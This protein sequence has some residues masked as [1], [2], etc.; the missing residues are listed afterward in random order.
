MD[1]AFLFKT[2]ISQN[3][4]SINITETSVFLLFS[5]GQIKFAIS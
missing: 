4:L 1:S 2:Y 5:F 3:Y